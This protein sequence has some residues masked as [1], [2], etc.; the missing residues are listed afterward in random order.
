MTRRPATTQLFY[1]AGQTEWKTWVT[2][3]DFQNAPKKQQF[4]TV[5]RVINFISLLIWTSI[6]HNCSKI[7]W[8][9]F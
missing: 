5:T 8:K 9:S 6:T 2:F 1:A 3:R 7:L 4:A